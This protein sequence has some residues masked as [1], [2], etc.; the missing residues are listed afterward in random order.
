MGGDVHSTRVSRRRHTVTRKVFVRDDARG[1]CIGPSA[2][3]MGVGAD[4]AKADG[5]DDVVDDDALNALIRARIVRV[6][7]TRGPTKS[8]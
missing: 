1:I 6:C 7:Q 3:A 8:C 5:V 2:R 4:A